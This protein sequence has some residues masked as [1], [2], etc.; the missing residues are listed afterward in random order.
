MKNLKKFLIL[1][2][3]FVNCF[4][5][6]CAQ[7]NVKVTPESLVK[8]IQD[9]KS[10]E[11]LKVSFD[12]ARDYYVEG[13]QFNEFALFLDKFKDKKDLDLYLKFYSGV[14]RFLQ[15]KFL[16]QSQ[17]WDE[18]FDKGNEYRKEVN[19]NLKTVI[20]SLKCADVYALEAKRYLWQLHK[21]MQDS[22]AEPALN[23]LMVCLNEYAKQAKDLRVVKDIA[24]ALSDNE[25]KGQALEAYKLYSQRIVNSSLTDSEIQNAAY[26]FYKEGNLELSKAIYDI[27]IDKVVKSYHKE[28]LQLEL[29][30]LAK[31]FSYNKKG[32]FDGNYAEKIFKVIVEKI[33]QDVFDEELYFTRAVNLE[34]LKE[35]GQA[36]DV[37]LKLLEKFPQTK[38]A[39][40]ANYKIAMIIVYSERNAKAGLSEMMKL[41]VQE[42][43][44]AQVIAAMYQVGL[45]NQWS[46]DSDKAKEYYT[47]AVDSAKD[48]YK[49]T[50]ELA[51]LRLK[52]IESKKDLDYNLKL[53]LDTVLNDLNKE[54]TGSK[55]EL[56]SSSYL[57]KTQDQINI[58]SVAYPP[59]SGCLQMQ[60]QYFWSGHLGSAVPQADQNEYS[61]SYANIGSKEINLVVVLPSGVLD[62]SIDFVDVE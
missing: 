20:D 59:D 53:F 18:Y 46:G 17:K 62:W 54:F 9:A 40:L 49:D 58:S 42:K 41:A 56:K 38:Y 12:S 52:E 55:V 2:L 11:D 16:E 23:D 27:F 15:L 60:L 24:K 31:Q 50:I 29:V 44:S 26:S 35:F 48:D 3:F 32:G 61:T 21:D 25:Q 36:K 37:Y 10:K 34:K 4:T 7:E 1:I 13:N 57:P 45:L 28:K 6:V 5:W 47:K 14:N 22:F 39:D 30:A 19:D 51:K 33:G 8:S 43:I